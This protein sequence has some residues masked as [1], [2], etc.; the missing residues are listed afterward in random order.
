VTHG[1]KVRGTVDADRERGQR[2]L[3]DPAASRILSTDQH[4]FNADRWKHHGPF[5]KLSELS[6]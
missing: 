1:W 4:D 3:C 5:T 2:P 6:G